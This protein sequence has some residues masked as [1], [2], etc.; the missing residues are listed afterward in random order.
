MA[1]FLGRVQE[2]EA[3]AATAKRQGR[4]G[5]A[6]EDMLWLCQA[7]RGLLQ[8]KEYL[9]AQ[10]DRLG[11]ASAALLMDRERLQSALSRL[12]GP[13]EASED[14]HDIAIR[15]L[16]D[17]DMLEEAHTLASRLAPVSSPPTPTRDNP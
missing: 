6:I 1:D 8:E 14:E 16:R 4:G 15:V 7:V 9:V 10:C 3:R 17:H 13:K 5:A 2:I 11:D 12:T